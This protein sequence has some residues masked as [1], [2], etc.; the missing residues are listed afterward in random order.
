[1]IIYNMNMIAYYTIYNMIL[2][3]IKVCDTNMIFESYI[4]YY[5]SFKVLCMRNAHSLQVCKVIRLHIRLYDI[6]YYFIL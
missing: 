4:T 1:M 3:H 6:C 2:L 5:Y